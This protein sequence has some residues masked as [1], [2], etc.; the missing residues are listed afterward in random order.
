M[1][2]RIADALCARYVKAAEQAEL[3]RCS[4]VIFKYVILTF[5]TLILRQPSLRRSSNA[6]RRKSL[7]HCRPLNTSASPLNEQYPQC[8][9]IFCFFKSLFTFFSFSS[10]LE[11]A[12]SALL[13]CA[14]SHLEFVNI[15]RFCL[16]DQN[17][18]FSVIGRLRI[19]NCH[20]ELLSRQQSNLDCQVIPPG[21]SQQPPKIPTSGSI[22]NS[23]TLTGR[24]KASPSSVICKVRSNCL[25]KPNL[26]LRD[27][28]MKLTDQQVHF[29]LA[30]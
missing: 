22:E 8:S 4:V 23:K 27:S 30:L 21:K 1:I 6:L 24:R 20:F 3:I 9:V 12:G 7:E 28:E 5:K 15:H 18:R 17:L 19:L 26:A 10:V 29:F 16:C 2:H 13:H 14:L 25:I 11:L